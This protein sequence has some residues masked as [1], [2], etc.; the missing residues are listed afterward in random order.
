M[1]DEGL[2]DSARRSGSLLSVCPVPGCSSL[3]MG[4]T[5][6]AHDSQVRSRSL[7]DVGGTCG[8]ALPTRGGFG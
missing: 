6:V 7:G 1:R 2:V 5:C 8:Y 4:G 3:T